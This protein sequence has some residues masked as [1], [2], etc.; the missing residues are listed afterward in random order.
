M[1]IKLIAS[2]VDGT[3][4][5][6]EDQ[7]CHQRTVKALH[8][9]A[10]AGILTTLATGRSFMTAWPLYAQLGM[11]A[12]LITINGAVVRDRIMT[13]QNHTLADE[14]LQAGLDFAKEQ[15]LFSIFFH[16]DKLFSSAEEKLLSRIGYM[17]EERK[18][19]TSFASLDELRERSDGKI[20]KIVYY[21]I[22]EKPSNSGHPMD[23]WKDLTEERQ[24]LEQRLASGAFP[25]LVDVTSSFV[26]NIELMPRGVDKGTGLA[27][28]CEAFGLLPDEVMCFGDNE[29]DLGM[30]DFAGHAVAMDNAPE[31]VKAHAR[32]VTDSVNDGGVGSMIEKVLRG[33]IS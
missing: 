23:N 4:L 14:V 31:S 1:A 21:H 7:S 20:N 32:Y 9:A 26:N 13:Y 6:L 3:L 24:C 18:L 12:P 16:G 17:E 15:G 22:N 27:E 19:F 8:D 29:N 2:D 5:C 10:E 25:P 28:L 30:F 11:T 33:E